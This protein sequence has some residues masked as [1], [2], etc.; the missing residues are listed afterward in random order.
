MDVFALYEQEQQNTAHNT[1]QADALDAA[2]TYEPGPG[3]NSP[4]IY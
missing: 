4:V 2:M 1:S 3:T